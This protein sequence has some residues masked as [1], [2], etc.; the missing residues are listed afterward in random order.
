[1]YDVSNIIPMNPINNP[2]NIRKKFIAPPPL[3]I[4]ADL[5]A[6]R[7]HKQDDFSPAIAVA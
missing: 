1:M 6:A 7:L 2:K 3:Y 4:S 5:Q